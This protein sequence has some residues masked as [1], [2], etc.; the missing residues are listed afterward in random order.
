MAGLLVAPRRIA[1]AFARGLASQSLYGRAFDEL[2]DLQVGAASAQFV[3]PEPAPMTATGWLRLAL[4]AV[5]GLAVGLTM[6]FLFLLLLPL[7]LWNN[8]Q[9]KKSLMATAKPT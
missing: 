4:A 2:L 5:A 9:R 3:A 8:L 7:G 1:S 6:W